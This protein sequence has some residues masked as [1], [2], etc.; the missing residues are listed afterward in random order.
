MLLQ[1]FL[2]ILIILLTRFYYNKVYMVKKKMLSYKRLF[3][4]AGFKVKLE[5]YKLLGSKT[6]DYIMEAEKKYGNPMYF[7]ERELTGFDVVISSFAMQPFIQLIN[8]NLI[9]GYFNTSVYSYRKFP[10][11]TEN[12]RRVIGSGIAF[13]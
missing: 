1:L 12:L 5:E 10:P 6:I 9:Q 4:E 2:T 8:L 11:I 3:E 13:S 7:H